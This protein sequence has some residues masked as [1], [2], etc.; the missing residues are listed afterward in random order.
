MS[1]PTITVSKL[2]SVATVEEGGVGSQSVTYTYTIT[3]TS[4]AST[5]PVTVG[6]VLDDQ[7]GELLGQAETANGNQPIV[8][9]QNG[10][11]TFTVTTTVPVQNAGDVQVNTVTV[12]GRTTRA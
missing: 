10:S 3:N 12:T 2:A 5:D 4:A 1:A 7:L 6:S 11:F 9:A 8:L